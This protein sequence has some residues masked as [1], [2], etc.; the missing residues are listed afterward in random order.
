MPADILQCTISR[1]EKRTVILGSTQLDELFSLANRRHD[2]I[3]ASTSTETRKLLSQHRPVIEARFSDGSSY[4]LQE[5]DKLT[6][7]K[8]SSTRRLTELR[9][10]DQF[11]GL[12][13]T[14]NDLWY[15]DCS[16]I[17]ISGPEDR[18]SYY[19][20]KISD[21]LTEVRDITTLAY[22][23]PNWA[24]SVLIGSASVF[25]LWKILSYQQSEAISLATCLLMLL[26]ASAVA[27]ILVEVIKKKWIPQVSF[28]WGYG[29]YRKA[30]AKRVV[31]FAA[32]CLPGWILTN[33]L[34]PTLH[35]SSK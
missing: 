24:I 34:V 4:S 33:L 11:G 17:S 22:S 12:T 32:V 15:R 19:A 30:M 1:S 3:A 10:I 8:T 20:D 21:I 9:V 29:K 2:E 18:A 14:L 5:V 31:T 23:M 26:P 7:I 25:S 6:K 16:I 28:D 13:I 27:S 35:L